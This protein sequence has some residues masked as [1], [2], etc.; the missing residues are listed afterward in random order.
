M[1]ALCRHHANG[2]G[3]HSSASAG[4]V[5]SLQKCVQAEMCCQTAAAATAAA[6]QYLGSD[7][8]RSISRQIEAQHEHELAEQQHLLMFQLEADHTHYMWM[9]SMK[10]K[11]GQAVGVGAELLAFGNQPGVSA[12]LEHEEHIITVLRQHLACERR[13]H[14]L[15]FFF[16]APNAEGAGGEHHAFYP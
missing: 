15:P 5:E 13:R 4:A 7:L 16:H 1:S 8:S 12:L 6:I 10:N 3:M 2:R 11:C 9:R 14:P